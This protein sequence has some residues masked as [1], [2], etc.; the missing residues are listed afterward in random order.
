MRVIEVVRPSTLTTK[1]KTNPGDRF[2][3]KLLPG[4]NEVTDGVME[5]LQNDPT[6]VEWKK[7]KFL[8]VY[9]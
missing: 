1:A 7:A 2:P 8:K 9:K 4:R 6:F 5:Q 3:V